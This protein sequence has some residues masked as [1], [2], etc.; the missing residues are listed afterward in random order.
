M[1]FDETIIH[2]SAPALCGIKPASLFSMNSECFS[3]GKSKLSEWSRDFV[4]SKR[5]F[6]PLK[7]ENGRF[8]MFVFDR[9][10]LEKVVSN[11]E[12]ALYLASKGYSLKKGF[13]GIIAQ[14]L[15]KLAFSVD[16]PHEVGLFLGYPLC[17]V[18]GFENNRFACKYSGFW[19]VYGDLNEA[20]RK[21]KMYKSCSEVCMKMLDSG[22]SVPMIVKKYN[23]LGGLKTGDKR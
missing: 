2:C 13:S 16:F 1:S 7:K 4:K 6:V 23:R 15:H 14:L 11:K 18:V 3:S 12:N 10:L 22:L 19:K 17:D 20:E 8:L 21:M 9:N 5:Y